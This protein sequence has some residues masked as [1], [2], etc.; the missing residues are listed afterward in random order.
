MHGRVDKLSR[1]AGIKLHLLTVRSSESHP[2]GEELCCIHGSAVG[3]PYHALQ[4]LQCHLRGYLPL[5]HHGGV[6]GVDGV[7]DR[8]F[9]LHWL[10]W[11]RVVGWRSRSPGS[12][13]CGCRWRRRCGTLQDLP[14]AAGGVG[15]AGQK[16][17]R[18]RDTASR[19]ALYVKC[20]CHI[21]FIVR[22][23]PTY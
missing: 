19:T 9:L 8:G 10:L 3:I 18:I 15:V 23:A 17:A 2:G 16:L 5:L 11:L 14:R 1:T 13:C 21:F 4:L 22:S 12:G 6:G 20:C 7:G